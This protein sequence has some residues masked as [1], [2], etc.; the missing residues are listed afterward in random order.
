M[1]RPMDLARKALALVKKTDWVALLVAR[2]TVGLE[3]ASTGWGKVTH[4]DKVTAYFG[5]ELHI[6]MPR[7]NATMASFTELVCGS[8]LILGLASRLSAAPLVVTMIVALLTAK[9][10]EIGGIVA[11]GPGPVSLD[12]VI[13]KLRPP[14]RVVKR[15]AA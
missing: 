14:V 5:D 13:A 10:H 3:F 1:N 4:L 9:A 7:L 6:P 12:A 8:L 2:L 15:A 11:L